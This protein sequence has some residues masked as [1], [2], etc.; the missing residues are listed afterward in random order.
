M[1]RGWLS[2]PFSNKKGG[3]GG[4]KMISNQIYPL[5]RRQCREVMTVIPDQYEKKKIFKKKTE[6]FLI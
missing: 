2:I 1:Q 3:K 4:L 5:V 6:R